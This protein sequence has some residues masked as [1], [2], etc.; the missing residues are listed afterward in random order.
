MSLAD[1]SLSRRRAALLVVDIQ[2]RLAPAM[3]PEALTHL[4]RNARIAIEAA[5]RLG[6]PIV[7]SEQYPKGLGRTI[8][9]I[10]EALA[11]AAPRRFEKTAFSACATE[12]FARLWQ[13]LDRDQ[14]IVCGMETHVCVWQSVRDLRGRGASVHVLS[15]AVSSRTNGNWRIGLDLA[16]AAGAVL[17]STETAVFDLLHEAGGDDFKALSKLIK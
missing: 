16:R 2:E 17:S 1:L 13:E 9:P 15:D 12:D 7:V 5:R 4:I 11:P 6:L 3:P 8:A 10:E 14:W